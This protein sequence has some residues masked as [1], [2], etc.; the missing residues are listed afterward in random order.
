VAT[1]G[2]YREEEKRVSGKRKAGGLRASPISWRK[3][4]LLCKENFKRKINGRVVVGFKVT[5][6]GGNYH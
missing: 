6:Q 3:S 4:A 1:G 2:D 5:D